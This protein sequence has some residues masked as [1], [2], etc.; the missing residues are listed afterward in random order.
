MHP[1]NAKLAKGIAGLQFQVGRLIFPLDD[2]R[3]GELHQSKTGGDEV[4]PSPPMNRRRVSTKYTWSIIDAPESEGWNA[5][6]CTE[7]RGPLNCISGIKD[8]LGDE[9]KTTRSVSRRRAGN[10]GHENYYLVSPRGKSKEEAIVDQENSA[11]SNFRLRVMH[12]GGSFFLLTKGGMT[13]EYLNVENVWFWLHHEYPTAMKGAV[14]NYNGS[15]FLV[16]ENNDLIIRERMG[17]ELTWINC[18]AVKKGKKVI[19]G[20]P[21]DLVPGKSPK[22]TP[23]DSLFFIS[24]TGG[25]LQ[26]TVSQNL[27]TRGVNLD[28]FTCIG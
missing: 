4:G 19:T 8:D 15:L 12:E 14:G 13:Y 9:D 21:W 26:L 6:Y 16:D 28:P 5:E 3:L 2:G 17:N 7:D 25:L 23:E 1:T 11:N 20:P 24:K 22:V 27:S 10:K 18:T